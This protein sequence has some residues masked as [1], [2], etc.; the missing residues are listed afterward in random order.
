MEIY[1]IIGLLFCGTITATYCAAGYFAL[2]KHVEVLEFTFFSEK[3]LRDAVVLIVYFACVLGIIITLAKFGLEIIIVGVLFIV[4][5]MLLTEF[6]KNIFV[7]CARSSSQ[8]RGRRGWWFGGIGASITAL[9]YYTYPNWLTQDIVALL[10]TTAILTSISKITLR[11]TLILFCTIMIWDVIAVF[12]TG[13]M[14]IA[15]GALKD[16]H[17][18]MLTSIPSSV[19]LAGKPLFNLGLGDIVLPG[20]LVMVAIREWKKRRMPLFPILTIIGYFC[21]C[22]LAVFVL[23]FTGMAQPATIY[24]MPA[25]TIGFFAAAWYHN[26][27]TELLRSL[28][29]QRQIN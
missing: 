29:M 7:C 16:L 1:F 5:I 13:I 12:G 23:F 20:F 15:A 3:P 17:T 10:I 14:V 11:Q 19:S 27:L 26:T 2:N 21:G 18:P 8:K 6:F 4:T 22:A 24:L 28:K 25:V 9:V